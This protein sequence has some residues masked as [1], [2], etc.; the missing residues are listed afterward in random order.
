M[1]VSIYAST[2]IKTYACIYLYLYLRTC[3]KVLLNLPDVNKAS[4]SWRVLEALYV[5]NT[6]HGIGHMISIHACTPGAS[7][8]NI[9]MYSIHLHTLAVRPSINSC[10]CLFKSDV[11]MCT[12]IEKI[13]CTC[14][15]V[16]TVVPSLRDNW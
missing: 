15:Y 16:H 4:C 11:C 10:K 14:T 13:I 7:N 3:F 6:C 12:Y 2:Y 8:T 9:H 1:Y 5:L